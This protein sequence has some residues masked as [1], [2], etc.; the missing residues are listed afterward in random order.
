MATDVPKVRTQS[1]ML[2]ELC[3]R[4]EGAN[5]KHSPGH[6]PGALDL[7]GP[8]E[9]RQ[10]IKADSRDKALSILFLYNLGGS[11]E[12]PWISSENVQRGH[13]LMTVG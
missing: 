8:E 11:K 1:Q 2:K 13:Q 12:W 4:E 6:N 5:S 9:S 7:G 3:E 10:E